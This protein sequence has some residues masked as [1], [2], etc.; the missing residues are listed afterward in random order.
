MTDS[1]I[2]SECSLQG[3]GFEVIEAADGQQALARVLDSAPDLILLDAMLPDMDG[4]GVYR[5]LKADSRANF[6]PVIFVMARTDIP[7]RLKQLGL[8]VDCMAKPVSLYDLAHR[9]STVLQRRS[10]ALHAG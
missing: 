7:S 1:E 9:I 5:L 6:M 8:N 4:L 2:Y 3:K 10:D